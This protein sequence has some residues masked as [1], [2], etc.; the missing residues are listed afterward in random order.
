LV[1]RIVALGRRE[2]ARRPERYR[3]A[4]IDLDPAGAEVRRADA[5]LRLTRKEFGVLH[6]L[7][8]AE[9]RL[10]SAETL[11]DRVWDENA[12]PFTSAVR[13]T[14]KNLR[15]KLGDPDVI[16]TVVGRGYRLR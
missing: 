13:T 12:D 6:E 10:V 14:V 9:G 2:A 1:A 8:R 15:R 3:W 4:D 7:M 5:F 11:L 16:E